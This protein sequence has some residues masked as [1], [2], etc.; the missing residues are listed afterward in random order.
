M[1]NC[2]SKCD[3]L[4]SST[5]RAGHRAHHQGYDVWLLNGA[6]RSMVHVIWLLCTRARHTWSAFGNADT[7]FWKG[8]ATHLPRL[9]T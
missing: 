5:T 8:Y 2:N 9:H 7:L 4:R 1:R 3:A 6:W